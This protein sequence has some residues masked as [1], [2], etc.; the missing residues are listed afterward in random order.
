MTQVGCSTEH[1]IRSFWA[2]S[3][4]DLFTF[5]E[6]DFCF[7]RNG[8]TQSRYNAQWE[9]AAHMNKLQHNLQHEMQGNEFRWMT[10]VIRGMIW[11]LGLEHFARGTSRMWSR[12][13]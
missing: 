2:F 12:G 8:V 1:S 10:C 7:F 3:R 4:M 9:A 11:G 6:D 5:Q 13:P